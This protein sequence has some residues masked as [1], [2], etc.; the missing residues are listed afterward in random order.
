MSEEKKAEN[1]KGFE[2]PKVSKSQTI[3][4][5]D[6]EIS[7]ENYGGCMDVMMGVSPDEAT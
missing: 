7:Y 3:C 6:K 1:K 4:S 2:K 5:A